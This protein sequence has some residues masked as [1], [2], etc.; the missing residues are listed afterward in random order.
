MKKL[1]I[2][3][4]EF[5]PQKGG[6]ANYLAGLAGA[7]PMDRVAV[8]A[9]KYD[10]AEN[11]DSRARYKIYRKNLISRMPLVWPRWL[12]LLF[13]LWRT[14]RREKTEAIL[15]GQ[16]LP[17][18]TAAMILN[19]FLRLPYFVS[20]HGMDILTAAESLRKKKL[21]NKI[22]EQ[23]S[24]VVANSEF[25][26]NE[27]L[28]LAV[29]ENKISVVYPCPHTKNFGVGACPDEKEGI[30]EEKILEIK[31]RL[32][33]ADK[34]I[35]LTVGRLVERKG[36]DKV[37]EALPAIL[38]KIPNALYVIVG[39]GPEKEKLQVLSSK[40]QVENNILF[41]GE[42]S[43]EKKTAFYQLCDVFVMIPRQIGPDVEGF[44][45][46]YLE[47]NQ[48]GKP[49]VA[50]RSGGVAEAVVDGA[51]GLVVDPENIN[52]IAEAVIKVLTD[53]SLGKKLGEQGRE[54]VEKEF[55]WEKQV[56]K[57]ERLIS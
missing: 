13:H 12:P 55:G 26:K 36:Q 35:I 7:L 29:P 18:G 47:A 10:G 28:K 42:I 20:C 46:V 24:G 27:L 8:L 53:E 14:A 23:T 54:R 33:L 3:T 40:L 5:P 38:E 6:I 31:N 22:L 45:T 56:E 4:I 51:T 37:I 1:L 2:A 57:I 17:V 11:F 39:D 50:G 25:T 16:V 52:Q 43:E 48:F 9:S 15:V 41:T 19:K 44:G 34:K 32:G 30:G 49:V 21:L